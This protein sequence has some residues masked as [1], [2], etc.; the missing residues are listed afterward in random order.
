MDRR[1]NDPSPA[2]GH[3]VDDQIV[4][5]LGNALS[6]ET[7][8]PVP[9]GVMCVR[10]TGRFIARAPASRAPTGSGMSIRPRDFHRGFA[11]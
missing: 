4:R 1:D 8:D 2:A 6:I 7:Q 10:D 5:S 3:A 9:A 11:L